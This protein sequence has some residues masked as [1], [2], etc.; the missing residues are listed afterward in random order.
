M[1][2]RKILGENIERE[3]KQK[4]RQIYENEERVRA[5]R[6]KKMKTG[7]SA[8]ERLKRKAEIEEDNG[9]V[10]ELGEDKA[11]FVSDLAYGDFE[12]NKRPKKSYKA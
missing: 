12:E 9:E 3:E 6:I 7:E 1:V 10:L 2:K 4:P 11:E 8:L 5:E